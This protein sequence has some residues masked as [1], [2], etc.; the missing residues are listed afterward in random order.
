MT[1]PNNNS[2]PFSNSHFMGYVKQVSP[3][4]V[5]AH[6][7]SSNLLS[8]YHHNGEKHHPGIVGS[9]VSIEGEEFG[10]IGRIL[11]LNLSEKERL[12]LTE[13]NFEHEDFHPIAKIEI[14]ISF[15]YIDS[16]QV[17]KGLDTFPHIGAKVFSCDSSFLQRYL[18]K[19]GLDEKET[20]QTIFDLA[21]LTADQNVSVNISSQS[22]FGRH[23]AVVGTTGGGK[24]WTV[25][26][27]LEDVLKNK[28]KAI[29]IDPTGEYQPLDDENISSYTTIGSDSY[30]HYTNLG[31]SDLFYL[32]RPSDKVQRP[33]LMEAIRSLKMVKLNVDKNIKER[34]KDGTVIK[35]AEIPVENGL[36]LKKGANKK[37]HAH[38]YHKNIAKIES[39]NL[40]FEIKNLPKQII[41]E[42]IW[43]ADRTNPNLFGGQSDSD[44]SF[45]AS[46]ISRVNNIILTENFQNIFGFNKSIPDQG[47]LI[48]IINSF[49]S[50]DSKHLLRISLDHVGF[51]FQAREILANAIGRYLLKQ[52]RTGEFKQNNSVILFIDEAHQF[53]NKTIQDE[54]SSGQSL[55]AFDLIAKESRKFGLFLCLATQM[56]RDI[57]AGT[58]SQMGTF[59]VHRLINKYDK[60]AVENACS[61]TN[62]AVMSFLPVLG[63][64]EAILLGVDF[65]MP[66]SVKI[67][68][69]I[70]KP[71][72]STPPVISNKAI[73]TPE[74]DGNKL[75]E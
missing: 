17:N 27:L 47:D 26:K 24:S 23:C 74:V 37:V 56:P 68:P 22:L 10:F 60:E 2:K 32:L 20:N 65:P 25:A 58:L 62:R 5:M 13:K 52:S 35:E 30:F 38:F 44:I 40:N 39:D 6:I 31:I 59:I 57:P 69:P 63:K 12:G 11:E 61:V 50:D 70:K 48:Q 46:L 28:G 16:S 75:T 19:F 49:L 36:L 42:C 3:E 33:K 9:Y 8:L 66:I 14:L 51:E 29:L 55:D 4:F 41:E 34:Y 45:C 18:L 15:N 7:P 53:L 73:V 43:D 71:N 72:S 67:K 64:G 54:Y 1:L 21:V